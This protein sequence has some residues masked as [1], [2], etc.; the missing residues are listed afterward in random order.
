MR[1]FLK[2]LLSGEAYHHTSTS[3]TTTIK[4]VLGRSRRI[5]PAR[6]GNFFFE[7]TI[8]RVALI[9]STVKRKR[10]E[11]VQSGEYLNMIRKA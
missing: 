8:I 1:Y 3:S 5:R 2:I 9:G 7:I 6:V 11:C 10:S 4:R